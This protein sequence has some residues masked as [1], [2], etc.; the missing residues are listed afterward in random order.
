MVPSLLPGLGALL[1]Q[2]FSKNNDPAKSRKSVTSS[3]TSGSV[4]STSTNASIPSAKDEQMTQAANF[5]PIAK[6]AP[7]TREVFEIQ[8]RL[9]QG[10]YYSDAYMKGNGLD[11]DFGDNTVKAVKAFQEAKNIEPTGVVDWQTWNEI[12][13]IDLKEGSA[14]KAKA[15]QKYASNQEK[16]VDFASYYVGYLEKSNAKDLNSTSGNAGSANFTRFGRDYAIMQQSNVH[17]NAQWC[18]MFVDGVMTEAFGEESARAM[19][20]GYSAYTPETAANLAKLNNDYADYD[21][22]DV[23]TYNG[24]KLLKKPQAGDTV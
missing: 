20:G 3:K 23:R 5:K 14:E 6:G 7:K 13:K 9:M 15:G 12:M 10:G 19:L 11:G 1:G 4:A 2:R 21:A 18:N 8:A 17:L 24:T 16:A 22:N